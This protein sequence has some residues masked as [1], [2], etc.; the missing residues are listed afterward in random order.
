VNAAGWGLFGT[1][2]IKT[3]GLILALVGARALGQEEFGTLMTWI[4]L[5]YILVVVSDF[6]LAGFVQREVAAERLSPEH[7]GAH[8]VKV[9][10]ITLLPFVLATAVAFAL[11]RPDQRIGV[12]ATVVLVVW[13]ELS[14]INGIFTAAL[15]GSLRF[16]DASNAVGIGRGVGSLGLAVLLIVHPPDG[17]PVLIACALL[18]GEV[19]GFA[20]QIRLVPRQS[21]NSAFAHVAGARQL[22]PYLINN[23]ANSAY[24]R[25]DVPVVGVFSG[26]RDAAIYSPASQLQSLLL[27]V[28]TVM[29]TGTLAIVARGN[30]VNTSPELRRLVN[31]TLLASIAAAAAAAA[32]TA[33]TASLWLP[34]LFGEPF[35]SSV[36]VVQLLMISVPIAAIHIVLGQCLIARGYASAISIGTAMALVVGL[37][38]L[39][40]G[41]IIDGAEGAA[42]AVICRDA[43]LALYCLVVW[44][45]STRKDSPEAG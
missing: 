30:F 16:K 28:P 9:L 12:G 14:L 15:T 1:L 5:L 41:T 6:G 11:V 25:G 31:R 18:V 43:L 23:L 4:G 42:I 39:V 44:R 27:S 21:F 34:L 3:Q 13:I 36:S 8:A 40:A 33:G 7:V 10:S 19:V 22:G 2:I 38:A 37:A 45:R 17:L 20:A 35:R 32:V 29:N 24:S 26:S